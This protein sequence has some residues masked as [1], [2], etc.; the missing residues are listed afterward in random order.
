MS[1][2]HCHEIGLNR[3]LSIGR[4]LSTDHCH[5][6]N[7]N[8]P[9]PTDY[10]HQV[11]VNRRSPTD[12]YQ[13][14]ISHH[15]WLCSIWNTPRVFGNRTYNV[16]FELHFA[17]KDIH[18][19]R[20]LETLPMTEIELSRTVKL[21]FAPNN[22]WSGTTELE[23]SR[24]DPTPKIWFSILNNEFSLEWLTKVILK[25][26]LKRTLMKDSSFDFNCWVRC[27]GR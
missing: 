27:P 1:I 21:L 13:R 24:G 8:S 9:L 4:P 20:W 10:C 12:P 15:N 19:S 23:D 22:E 26:I 16:H 6:L 17:L 14:L 5:K 2:A 7:T 3:P 18:R 11:I 25:S